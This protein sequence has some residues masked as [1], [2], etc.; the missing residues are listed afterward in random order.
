MPLLM[1]Y[2]NVVFDVIKNLRIAVNNIKKADLMDS[3]FMPIQ[4]IES[5]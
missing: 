3:P 4:R 2:I 5:F 1:R